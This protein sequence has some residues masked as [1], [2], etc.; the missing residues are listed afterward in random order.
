MRR[1]RR[2]HGVSK[3]IYGV[4]KRVVD[5]DGIVGRGGREGESGIDDTVGG[6]GDGDG[7][8]RS[9]WRSAWGGGEDFDVGHT[10]VVAADWVGDCDVAEVAELDLAAVE[11]DCGLRVVFFF[12]F[13]FFWVGVV[14]DE[15]WFAFASLEVDGGDGGG[16]DDANAQGEGEHVPGGQLCWVLFLRKCVVYSSQR[17]SCQWWRRHRF[18]WCAGLCRDFE[19][20]ELAIEIR[21]SCSG[22]GF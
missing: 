4:R 14:G 17:E 6:T 22:Y 16:C 7:A 12:F 5:D 21:I 2:T 10:G 8:G 15:E 9:A 18:D 3:R 20:L 1:R 13:F 19:G 11:F